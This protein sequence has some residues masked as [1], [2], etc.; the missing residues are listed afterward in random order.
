MT[1]KFSYTKFLILLWS[2]VFSSVSSEAQYKQKSRA[3]HQ[4]NHP[5]GKV[6]E[7]HRHVGSITDNRADTESK[8]K[9]FRL[10]Q[11]AWLGK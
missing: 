11:C 10:L 1:P 8:I 4:Q 3:T 2:A 5:R 6:F 7:Q 9:K